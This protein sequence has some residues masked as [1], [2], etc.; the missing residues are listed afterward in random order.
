MR[1]CRDSESIPISW[2]SSAREALLTESLI[3]G[4]SISSWRNG[5]SAPERTVV[6]GDGVN[7]ILLARQAGAL[8]CA[9]LGGITER[10]N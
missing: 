1:I 2:K 3:R 7:D 10:R 9:F 5:R 8:S 6:I 4:C